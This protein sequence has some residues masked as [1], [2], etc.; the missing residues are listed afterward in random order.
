MENSDADDLLAGGALVGPEFDENGFDTNDEGLLLRLIDTDN[1]P[2]SPHLQAMLDDCMDIEWPFG[3]RQQSPL[4]IE[5]PRNPGIDTAAFSFARPA[6]KTKPL[7][8]QPT[9]KVMKR[10]HSDKRKGQKRVS[11]AFPDTS[12][13]VPEE[14]L[15]QQL[16]GRL[17]AREESEAVATN[18]QKEMEA[19][20]TVLQEE[21]NALKD[22]IKALSSKLQKRTAETRAYKSQTESWKSK[23]GKI[24][25]FFNDLGT[26]YQNLRG[27][28]I[29]IK[30]ARKILDKERREIAESIE[31]VK[32]RMSQ[33]S[34]VSLEGRG[35]TGSLVSSL[36][37][38]LDH[39]R[40]R[41][42]NF[43]S[44]LVDEKKRSRL[45]ELYIQNSSRAQDKKL[46][47]VRAKQL[48][49]IQRLESD[50]RVTSKNYKSSHSAFS[51]T[52]EKKVEEFLAIVTTTTESLSNGKMDVQ[53]CQEII[54]T[55]QSCMDT[56]TRQ[57]GEDIGTHSKIT[58]GLVR[59]LEQHVQSLNDSVSDGSILL[60]HL[61]ANEDCCNDLRSKLEEVVPA[62]KSLGDDLDGLKRQEV[63][64]GQQME[65]LETRLSEVKLPERFEADYYHISEK[66]GLETEIQRLTVSLK[67]TEG[68]L[69]AQQLDGEQ[70]AQELRET[71]A[72]LHQAETSIVKLEL[73]LAILQGRT[74]EVETKDL[75]QENEMRRLTL[76]LKQCSA[77]FERQLHELLMEKSKIEMNA[78][79]TKE[80]LADS[81]QKLLKEREMRIQDLEASLSGQVSS[82]ATRIQ[83]LEAIRTEQ[84]SALAK[85]EAEI[86][87]LR[88]Q[89]AALKSEQTSVREQ[90]EEAQQR[91]NGFEIEF[92][93]TTTDD[94]QSRKALQDSFSALQKGF[95]K[96][97]ENCKALQDTLSSIQNQLTRAVRKELQ[98]ANCA[99]NT[100]ESGK[101]KAKAEI[102]S[103][104]KRVQ[105]SELVTKTVR[106]TFHR[107]GIARL[108]QPLSEALN[109][110]ERVLQ[111]KT[112][113]QPTTAQ[114]RVQTDLRTHE[115]KT[116]VN[117][118][119]HG[120]P[121]KRA[122]K[123][124]PFSSILGG[125]SPINHPAAD[126][127]LFE[128]SALAHTPKR[129]L[130]PPETGVPSRP[131]KYNPLTDDPP[132]SQ[133]EEAEVLPELNCVAE[134]Q[135]V[136]ATRTQCQS[137]PSAP[138]GQGDQAQQTVT[139]R[140]VSFASRKLITEKDVLQ[141]PDSQ[142]K[143]KESNVLE[144]SI[145]EGNLSRT[146]RW[147]YSKR[148]RET[149]VRQQETTSIE[150]IP[151][152][153]E[154]QETRSKKAKTSSTSSVV[155]QAETGSERNDRRRSPTRLASGSSRTSSGIPDP[156]QIGSN[157]GSRRTGRKSRGKPCHKVS[158]LS[159]F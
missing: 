78:Q 64:L 59:T 108:E 127:E 145:N 149:S 88:E 39:M 96:K 119:D 146:N 153:V 82:M 30:A 79:R 56:T 124:V 76:E 94:E 87:L 2:V 116:P 132:V 13:Q 58:E 81:Q 46:D 61:S 129:A 155:T 18:L 33:I 156:G 77:G 97:E 104:L 152:Q 98:D 128:I 45:L 27:E 154:E 89:E 7:S 38:E 44:Q 5:R 41:V 24:K 10:R 144:S 34:Q 9:W 105:D 63:N 101:S 142:G 90:L 40:E 150:R 136:T 135:Q 103:L 111:A 12:G 16:I 113:R 20:I 157:R 126:S 118:A 86:Q 62:F 73:H 28:A 122:G 6:Q 147:T 29:H 85:R 107:A 115:P 3:Q 151:P 130:A 47:E 69:E 131:E 109:Q 14:I 117:H 148:Q 15:F 35:E 125:L 4:F 50:F 70:K 43:Q 158:C 74:S 100:L 37:Q 141:D 139:G 31:D 112:A 36:K 60:E 134:A 123:I 75:E 93:K 102:H 84:S 53:Q 140:K 83:D 25:T 52:F 99:R 159:E 67:L 66:I 1:V 17:K 110:L 57:L 80:H 137:R 22:E 8:L 114:E 92:M 71:T 26:D 19:N 106:E 91:S 95:A 138:I 32:A 121:S 133:A 120:S 23:L 49:V 54:C 65:S 48:E 42:Q 143:D 72:K 51:E 21:N 68:K 11:Y 55:F